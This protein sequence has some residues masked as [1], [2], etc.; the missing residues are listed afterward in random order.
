M[1]GNT[2]SRVNLDSGNNGPTVEV[3]NI[4]T[5]VPLSTPSQSA[6]VIF[7]QWSSRN[8]SSF[9]NLTIPVAIPVNPTTSTTAYAGVTSTGLSIHDLT[10]KTPSSSG[11]ESIFNG[12]SVLRN[13]TTE[14]IYI[15]CM[16]SLVYRSKYKLKIIPCVIS[17][18]DYFIPLPIAHF[19]NGL[20]FPLNP[21]FVDFFILINSQPAHVHPNAVRYIMALIVL[22]RRV[23]VE[24]SVLILRTLFSI[25]RMNNKTFFV[26]PRS[27]VVTLFDSIPSKVLDWREKCLYVECHT[28]FPFPPLVMNL[29]NS[30]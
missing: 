19:L 13:N 15:A 26:R 14:S 30:I 1:G 25:L 28:S 9:K 3:E 12:D 17:M 4:A 5:T 20:S 23:G 10:R 29:D 7:I 18:S 6:T 8:F 21:A 27:N 16:Y 24:V 11:P 22:C 2:S